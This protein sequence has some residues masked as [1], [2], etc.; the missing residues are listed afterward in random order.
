VASAV[1]SSIRELPNNPE[2]PT[3][4]P[5][6]EMLPGIAA[7]QLTDNSGLAISELRQ[8]ADVFVSCRIEIDLELIPEILS[9]G[10]GERWQAAVR[11]VLVAPAGEATGR[12]HR[13]PRAGRV[14][15]KLTQTDS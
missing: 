9:G 4:L 6:S 1:D 13:M 3:V 7:V 8:F 11:A 15:V 5:H 14:P 10:G 12:G 2:F